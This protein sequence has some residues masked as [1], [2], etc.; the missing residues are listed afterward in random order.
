MY[1][2]GEDFCTKMGFQ[3]QS[4]TAA[5]KDTPFYGTCHDYKAC[6]FCPAF[7]CYAVLCCVVL[8]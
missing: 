6:F 3:V 2:S 1:S 8:V 4:V 7:S 5:V